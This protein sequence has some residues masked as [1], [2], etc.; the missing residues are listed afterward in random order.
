MAHKFNPKWLEVLDSP[1]RFEWMRP[2]KIVRQIG[3]A[4]GMVAMDVGAGTGFFAFPMAE[5]V[6]EQGKVLAVD[7]MQ[8]MLDILKKRIAEKG[9]KNVEPVLSTEERIEVP[10][11]TADLALI[12]DVLHELEG[13]N[14]LNE[15]RRILKPGGKFVVIDWRKKFELKGPPRFIRLKIPKAKEKVESAGFV[16]ESEFTPT[17]S[18]YGLIFIKN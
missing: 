11:D 17:D 5:V 12:V 2:D 1:K 6:G 4:K 8:E 10:D 7:I 3:L 14:T 16:F 15:I 18:H 13:L 9:C